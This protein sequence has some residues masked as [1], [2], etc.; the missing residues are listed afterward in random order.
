MKDF[1]FV[2]RIPLDGEDDFR[3]PEV[4]EDDPTR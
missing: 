2:Y 1:N 3:S 4:S